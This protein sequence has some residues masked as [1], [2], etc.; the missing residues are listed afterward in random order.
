M[1]AGRANEQSL[2]VVRTKFDANNTLPP[3]PSAKTWKPQSL[4]RDAHNAQLAT[5]HL[6]KNRAFRY[7][8]PSAA[9]ASNCT[10]PTFACRVMTTD[11]PT[12]MPSDV[13]TRTVRS[14]ASEGL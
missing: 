6:I 12:G 7:H 11:A 14:P 3:K 10:T 1:N 13:M 8:V 2:C 5:R 4:K 9:V